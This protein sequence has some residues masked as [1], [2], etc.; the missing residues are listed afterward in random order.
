[1]FLSCKKEKKKQLEGIVNCIFF[2]FCKFA[3]SEVFLRN[4]G[5]D[6]FLTFLSK[7]SVLVLLRQLRCGLGTLRLL[8]WVITG[9]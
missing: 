4:E 8:P 2:F 9:D 1:M 5:E 7:G 6:G 3:Q